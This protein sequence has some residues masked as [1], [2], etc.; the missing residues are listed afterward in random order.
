M[1]ETFYWRRILRES[2]SFWNF[3]WGRAVFKFMGSW[4]RDTDLT[5]RFC[6]LKSGLMLC[7]LVVGVIIVLSLTKCGLTSFTI[8]SSILWWK[9]DVLCFCFLSLKNHCHIKE[10]ITFQGC[11]DHFVASYLLSHHEKTIEN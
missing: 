1:C 8:H 4:K 11:F 5:L 6:W 9:T 3:H 10:M 2:D 7:Y